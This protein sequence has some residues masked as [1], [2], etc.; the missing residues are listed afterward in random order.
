MLPSQP[1]KIYPLPLLPSI[2]LA[3]A[4]FIFK[5]ID[6]NIVNTSDS[7]LLSVLPSPSLR[8]VLLLR[9]AVTL[10]LPQSQYHFLSVSPMSTGFLKIV[11]ISH[12]IYS[13]MVTQFMN[14]SI[15][16]I[17][18]WPLSLTNKLGL[19]N[20]LLTQLTNVYNNL[21]LAVHLNW[22]PK[23]IIR[24]DWFTDIKQINIRMYNKS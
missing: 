4:H 11:V 9:A 10:C 18:C 21:P 1:G 19:L 23:A 12:W 6:I 5:A 13:T 22:W 20:N 14:I 15:F 17:V 7:S 16:K 3:N 2:Y 8:K 24:G